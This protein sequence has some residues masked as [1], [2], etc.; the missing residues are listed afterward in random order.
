MPFGVYVHVPFCAS[1][2]DYCD[3]ATWTDRGHLIDAVRRRVRHRRRAHLPTR[4]RRTRDERVLRR[5]HAVVAA[6]RAARPDPRRDPAR[7]APRSRSSATPTRVD[8]DEARGTARRRCR[9]DCRSACSRCAP[10]VLAALGPDARS[11]ERRRVRSA[12]RATRVRHVQPRPHLRHARRVRRRL[13]RDARSRARARPSTRQRVRA[14]CR[15]GH[16]AREARRRRVCR[17][18]PTTTT[19]PRSTRSPTTVLAAAGLDWYE[20]SNWARPGHECRHNLLYWSAGRLPRVGCAAHGHT[21]RYAVVE[22]PDPRAL[23]R[24]ASTAGPRPGP[25]DEHL[26]AGT[27]AEERFALA[28]APE[29]A[30]PPRRGR[31]GR[32]EAAAPVAG[33]SS[34]RHRRPGSC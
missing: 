22:R 21:R 1:R 9:R 8:P 17:P 2:C 33:G 30:P 26:D 11:G 31:A 12:G 19:R 34:S 25:G 10:H 29:R 3:F 6:G 32:S 27:R 14:R 16:P 15:A 5:R 28:C 20:V 13:A 23:R 4:R 24:S 18:R 7:R